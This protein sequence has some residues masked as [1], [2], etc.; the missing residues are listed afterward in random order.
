MLSLPLLTTS[1]TAAQDW[2]YLDDD[3][4]AT[5]G[6]QYQR[7][8]QKTIMPA[9]VSIIIIKH[10]LLV[11]CIVCLLCAIPAIPVGLRRISNL[12]L[13]PTDTDSM[14]REQASGSR[15]VLIIAMAIEM[16]LLVI[17]FIGGLKENFCLTLVASV[18][19]LLWSLCYMFAVRSGLDVILLVLN[20]MSAVIGLL[21][22]VVVRTEYSGKH[23]ESASATVGNSDS[24]GGGDNEEP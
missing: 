7:Q 20:V 12:E 18:M 5:Y 22:S 24:I 8:Q 2:A 15:I 23:G 4:N 1:R 3:G 9:R 10:V 14:T 17:T 19:L 13:H 21:L 16:I 6:N 11:F